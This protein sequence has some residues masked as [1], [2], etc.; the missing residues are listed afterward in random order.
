M[1]SIRIKLSKGEIEELRKFLISPQRPDG[2][3]CFHELQGFLFAVASCPEMVQ[4]S[5][6]LPIISDD[7]DI[8]F[9]DQSEAERILSLVMTLYNQV[10]T[11]VLNRS[12]AMP[13]GCKFQTDID[14][15]FE[16]KV[17]ISEWSRG[18]MLGHDWLADVW[19][20]YVPESLDGECGSSAMVLSFFASR[21]LAEVY[22]LETTTTPR[23]RKPKKSFTEFAEV[24]RGLFPE[25]LS[26]YAHLGRTISEVIERTAEENH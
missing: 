14:A 6:W 4:P 19:D 7:E 5:D 1:Q 3:L 16:E 12:D 2:T 9:N 15:N 18:F 13:P 10:N 24:V 22:Y 26:S 23:H 11:A 17:A 8:G 20:D 21:Q 25:A